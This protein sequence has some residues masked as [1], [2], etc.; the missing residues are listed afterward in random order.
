[1]SQLRTSQ[2]PGGSS[3]VLGALAAQGPHPEHAGELMLF[4]QLV[5]AWEF[6]GVEYGADGGSSEHTGEWHFGWVLE[7]RAIQDVLITPARGDWADGQPPDVY[8]TSIRFFDPR[9]GGWRVVWADPVNGKLS[10]LV[11]RQ[12][13]DEIVM[14]GTTSDGLPMRW[15]WSEVTGTSAHWRNLVSSDE[16][17]TWRL[18][19][20][21][22]LRRL[23]EGPG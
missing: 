5:G 21:M 9:I 17:E 2:E 23:G 13:G 3:A 20:E 16:G 1:M 22:R 12:V 10:V 4:G 11:A 15:I 18:R 7:G 19:E 6:E 8:G 14:E